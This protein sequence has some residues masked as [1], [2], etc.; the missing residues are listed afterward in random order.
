VDA[1]IGGTIKGY[2]ILEQIGAGG[3][4]AVYRAHQPIVNREVAIKVILPEHANQPEF[5]RRFETEA[6][7]IA[8]LEH[9][10]IVPLYDY[11]RDPQGAYLVTRFMRGGSLRDALQ[12][13]PYDP[14]SASRLLDQIASALS[15]AHRN[16]VVHRDIKPSNILLDEDGNAYLTDFGIAKELIKLDEER[17]TA[18]DMIVGSPD[19]LSPEQAR[20]QPVLPQTD[21]FCL[22]IVL[23]EMLA[24]EHPFIDE[25]PI[26][27]IYKLMK[28]PLPEIEAEAAEAINEIIQKATAKEPDQR[29]PDV[30][31]FARAFRA[32]ATLS[33]DAE[34]GD[35]LVAPAA[36]PSTRIIP[37]V[38]PKNPFKGLRAFQAAD[39]RDFFGREQLTEKLLREIT[40]SGD[41]AR[42]LAIVGPSGSGK[43]SLVRAGLIPKIRRG[44][45]TGSERWYVAEMIPGAHPLEELEIALLQIASRSV[46]NLHELLERNERGLVRACQLILPDDDSQLLLV[47][48]QFE[49]IFTLVED[50]EQRAHFMGLL[51]NAMTDE[52]SRLRV[53]ITLRAD[54]YDR[55]LQYPEFGELMRER[56]ETIL[57]MSSSE[58]EQA[59]TRP[60]ERIGITYEEGLVPKIIEEV[61]A[62][63]GALPLLQYALTMLFEARQDH[64][65]TH[66]GY[67]KVGGAVGALAK[68][69]EEIYLGLDD[70]RREAAQR[71]FL[72]LV[73][74]DEETK[75][76]R[77]RTDRTEL[78]G[79]IPDAPMLDEVIDKFAS[80]RL[81]SLDHDPATRMPT[82]ELAHEA[83]LE[84][85]V[86]L[87]RWLEDARDDIRM[88]RQ[89]TALTSDWLFSERDPSFTLRGS[90]LEM[91]ETWAA[92]KDELLT[93]EEQDYLQTSSAESLARVEHEAR[94]ER[95]S[96]NFLRGLVAV[97]AIATVVSLVMFS[98]ARNAQ[99]TAENEAEARATQQSIAEVESIRAAEEADARAT[100]Q[101]IAEAESSRASIEARQSFVRELAASALNLLEI[102]P[103]LSVLLTLQ[104]VEETY[105]TDGYVMEEAED[106][107]HRAVQTSASRLLLSFRGLNKYMRVIAYSP[108]GNRLV[109]YGHQNKYPFWEIKG[110]T[111][112]WDAHT[113]E[114]IFTIPGILASDIWS[115]NNYLATITD[116]DGNT[117]ELTFWNAYTGEAL[118]TIELN[119]DLYVSD[120]E[121][122]QPVDLTDEDIDSAAMS[123]DLKYF[124]LSISPGSYVLHTV[125][126]LETHQEVFRFEDRGF[127][128]N[129]IFAVSFSTEGD[130]MAVGTILSQVYLWDLMSGELI[131]SNR[132]HTRETL[133]MDIEFLPSSS[134]FATA[135]GCMIPYLPFKGMINFDCFQF[136]GGSGGERVLGNAVSL[137]NP[138]SGHENRLFPHYDYRIAL[139]SIEIPV[140]SSTPDN[141]FPGNMEL[142]TS[143]S[144]AFTQDGSKLALGSPLS[145]DGLV[146]I[147]DIATGREV[148]SFFR[149]NTHIKDVA[150]SP[151]GSLLAL[152]DSNDR[153]TTWDIRSNFGY[154]W[155]SFGIPYTFY[156]GE[157]FPFALSPDGNLLITSDINGIMQIWD[158]AS[159]ELQMRFGNPPNR[160]RQVTFSSSGEYI[161]SLSSDGMF[162]LWDASSGIEIL[163]KPDYSGCCFAFDPQGN[164]LAITNSALDLTVYDLNKALD[165]GLTQQSEIFVFRQVLEPGALQEEITGIRFIHDGSTVII[166]F[167]GGTV[168]FFNT[169]TGDSE[170]VPITGSSSS[171]DSYP[172]SALI[173]LGHIDGTINVIDSKNGEILVELSGHSAEIKLVSFS[174]DGKLL[175]S[176]SRDDTVKI[177]D[178]STGEELLTLF[179]HS[180]GIT[181]VTLSPY[182][183]RLYAAV[184]DGTV[185]VYL[186]DIDELIALAYTRLTRWFT[187]EECQTYLHTDTCPSPP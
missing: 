122:I 177:W 5:I 180:L 60:V 73:S 166:A 165:S 86:R 127:P 13:S 157:T 12:K 178:V 103:Q 187:P 102:D 43:S 9:L 142:F 174:S 108:D 88:Q 185:R 45:I 44:E 34:I 182:N 58:L 89:L 109:T 150:F 6:Q 50:E 141:P 52:R 17:L 183:T 74:L 132:D 181:D 138:I 25:T 66:D 38:E 71:L 64:T 117:I 149:P 83:I 112:V 106:A 62:Q 107:L 33:P 159:G 140:G 63:P 72:R 151:N 81:L 118:S 167:E 1:I 67:Q 143:W 121:S 22:G 32:A 20:T 148:L 99:R 48:D 93:P 130:R 51:F 31:D 172:E 169:E 97:F 37:L 29:Y 87:R 68:R 16:N 95:R 160:I 168:Q 125:W 69:A 163:S 8:H 2:E 19:Y 30:L 110:R 104:A 179:F 147:W 82:V 161:G 111:R 42:F 55:P 137:W 76:T 28:D 65:L 27:R 91:Y 133:I 144:L 126:D 176:V 175:T 24:G 85:W 46:E 18:T 116:I 57:P 119:I 94:L 47:V 153:I 36:I 173:A 77:R 145:P 134:L 129:E 124:S 158:T 70:T 84:E 4:G 21:I 171:M 170:Y 7:I 90:R 96:R 186:L 75:Y 3:Y 131:Y 54:Y 92:E 53:V 78:L 59:I 155:L 136:T 164:Y 14:V 154:E 162:N 11:W 56:M 15:F 35:R 146:M 39:E 152:I 80:Q 23:Y 114:M 120:N 115:I 98:M 128:T 41:Y 40:G 135:Y 61:H 123:N 113:G 156:T 49:E 105:A 139:E 184:S 79:I 10:H 100:Q 26:E 101:A